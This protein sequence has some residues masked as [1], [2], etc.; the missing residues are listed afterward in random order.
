[1]GVYILPET[2]DDTVRP[3]L[4]KG[5]EYKDKIVLIIS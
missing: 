4:S 2:F 5:E 1:M 3:I